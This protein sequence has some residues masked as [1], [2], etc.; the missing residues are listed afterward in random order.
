MG[1]VNKA[2]LFSELERRDLLLFLVFISRSVSDSW[3]EWLEADKT[4]CT[5]PLVLSAIAAL[6]L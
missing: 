5:T 6:A 1:F 4:M 2:D 3:S